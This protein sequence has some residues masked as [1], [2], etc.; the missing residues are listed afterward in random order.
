MDLPGWLSMERAMQLLQDALI[1]APEVVAATGCVNESRFCRKFRA[2][3]NR[4]FA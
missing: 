2:G 1:S 4:I 3:K